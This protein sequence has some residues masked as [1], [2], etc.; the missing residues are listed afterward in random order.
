MVTTWPFG[1][2]H[3]WMASS[4]MGVFLS[5][6]GARCVRRTWRHISTSDGIIEEVTW[7]EIDGGGI[8]TTDAGPVLKTCFGFC[9]A[10]IVLCHSQEADGCK[11]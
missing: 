8:V 3:V 2:E 4:T 1:A 5:Q 6:K 11:S 10:G 7:D 9:T